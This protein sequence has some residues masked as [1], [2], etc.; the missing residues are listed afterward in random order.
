MEYLFPDGVACV[1]CLG[2]PVCK[3]RC[4]EF[5]DVEFFAEPLA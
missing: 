1:A 4:L 2:W 3:N 5:A